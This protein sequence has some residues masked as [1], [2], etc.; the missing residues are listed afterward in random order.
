[1]LADADELGECVTVDELIEN[2]EL[3]RRNAIDLL[4]A[5]EDAG[6]GEFRLGR[7]G[8]PSRLVW[9]TDAQALVD[10]VLG[11]EVGP[12]DSSASESEPDPPPPT[13]P[14]SI[15]A[16][17]IDHAFMLRPDLRIGLSLPVDLS[18]REAAVLGEWVRNLSFER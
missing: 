6:A 2:L 3:G 5:L 9:S 7:K 16:S 11:R 13:R 1:M 12:V 15:P 4:R 8:H 18:A 10:K 17:A 14:R